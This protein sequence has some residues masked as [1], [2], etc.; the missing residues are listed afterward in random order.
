MLE[1][2]A[3]VLED[4]GD[5]AAG[6][7]E[8]VAAEVELEALVGHGHA[9]AA[10]VPAGLDDDDLL[11]LLGQQRGGGQPCGAGADDDDVDLGHRARGDPQLGEAT[12]R[13]ARVPAEAGSASSAK[14]RP[15]SRSTMRRDARRASRSAPAARRC[16]RGCPCRTR[17]AGSGVRV[18]SERGR[19]PSN[20][21][22]SRLAAA[23]TMQ[24]PV[25]LALICAAA[26][27]EVVEHPA[28]QDL[29]RPLE[30]QR[31]PRRRLPASVGIGPQQLRAGP[32][33]SISS[34]ST[35][36]VIVVVVVSWPAKSIR[37]HMRLDLVVVEL[38]PLPSPSS[39]AR[40]HVLA[41]ARPA[42]RSI[43]SPK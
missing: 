7:L 31:P 10:E 14:R 4:L 12:R 41:R 13:E 42:R 26:D 39:S 6:V 23:G 24:H 16:R 33:C 28:V 32:G 29:D 5:A 1:L 22:G 43:S 15:G 27:L 9:A 3:D 18:M 38:A 2:L 30:A 21:S 37:A 8:Q 35:A 34:L 20:F 17:R 11:A 36:E 25:A 19:G 40:D